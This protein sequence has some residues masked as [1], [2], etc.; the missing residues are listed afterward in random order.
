MRLLVQAARHRVFVGREVGF[1]F[2]EEVLLQAVLH[3]PH[4]SARRIPE[5]GLL[6]L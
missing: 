4:R 1:R 5:M 6:H 2:V 3:L